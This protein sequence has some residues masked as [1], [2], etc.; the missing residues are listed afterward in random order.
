MLTKMA[1][2]FTNITDLL[3]ATSPELV[4]WIEDGDGTYLV[5][6]LF[7]PPVTVIFPAPETLNKIL[8]G[9]PDDGVHILMQHIIPGVSLKRCAAFDDSVETFVPG[10]VLNVS[11]CDGQCVYLKNGTKIM[12]VPYQQFENGDQYS[13]FKAT[14]PIDLVDKVAGSAERRRHVRGRNEKNPLQRQ[15]ITNY[16]EAKY[17][18]YLVKRSKFPAKVRCVNPYAEFIVNFFMFL[19]SRPDYHQYVELAVLLDYDP[20]ASF[21]ILLEPYLIPE[22]VNYLIPEDVLKNYE[23]CRVYGNVFEQY[24]DLVS[25]ASLKYSDAFKQQRIECCAEQ[26]KIRAIGKQIYADCD[27]AYQ[28]LFKDTST[29]REY[30]KKV[31]QLVGDWRK[32]KWQDV[33]RFRF[34]SFYSCFSVNYSEITGAT[35]KIALIDSEFCAFRNHVRNCSAYNIERPDTDNFTTKETI[36]VMEK[37]CQSS[38]YLYAAPTVEEVR[39]TDTGSERSSYEAAKNAFGDFDRLAGLK[40]D[41]EYYKLYQRNPGFSL[42]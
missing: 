16:V 10:K 20:I 32:K 15:M 33:F 18:T 2:L 31:L 28:S 34:P 11:H 7:T 17:V 1:P 42:D 39:A 9:N 12:A 8:T 19:R 13:V 14:G 41:L 38:A 24:Y 35:V 5:G 6:D 4:K 21:Y 26:K 29:L 40:R 37:F 22:G 23:W 25:E 3:K 30:P 27:A 36:G